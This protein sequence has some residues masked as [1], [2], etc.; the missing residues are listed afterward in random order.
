MDKE[1]RDLTEEEKIKIFE[2]YEIVKSVVDD[3]GFQKE[4]LTLKVNEIFSLLREKFT[5]IIQILSSAVYEKEFFRTEILI[6]DE[7][8][9]WL[10]EIQEEIVED[11]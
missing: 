4:I 3:K 7:F 10:A 11:L 8:N 1:K 5:H 6:D 2:A 9:K